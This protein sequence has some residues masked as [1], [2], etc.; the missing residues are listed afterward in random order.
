MTTAMHHSFLE[1]GPLTQHFGLE[2]IRKA[3]LHTYANVCCGRL[4]IRSP[5]FVL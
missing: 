4:P 1:I 3:E 2:V 5:L